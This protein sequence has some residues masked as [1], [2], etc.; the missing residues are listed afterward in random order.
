MTP[1]EA[2]QCGT[3]NAAEL[4]RVK[5]THGSITIGKRANFS[6]F[7]GDPLSDIHALLDCA[8]TVIGGDVVFQK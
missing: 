4:L 2:I 8:M 6:I 5:D 3:I 7:E 1:M